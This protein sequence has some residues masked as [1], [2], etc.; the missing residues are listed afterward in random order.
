MS[1]LFFDDLRVG[2]VIEAGYSVLDEAAIIDF[3]EQWDPQDFHTDAEAA[4][5]S[6]F[7]GLIASGFHT[8][9]TA[10][11]HIVQLPIF[12]NASMGSPGIQDLAWIEPVRPDDVLTTEV[13]VMYLRPSTRRKDRGYA[14]LEI[15]SHRQGGT[16]VMRYRTVVIF[17]TRPPGSGAG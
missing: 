6:H 14:G 8:L 15:R 9:L 17:A 4:G 7:G 2:Q 16:L 13:E 11:N 5:K 12:Q 1:P 10:F 3:A